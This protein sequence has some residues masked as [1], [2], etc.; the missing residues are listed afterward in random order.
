[1][2]K[3]YFIKKSMADYEEGFT[4]IELLVVISIISL[5]SSVVLGTLNSARDKARSAKVAVDFH[6]IAS[7]IELARDNANAVIRVITGS[8][9]S[10]CSFAG[11]VL[12]NS[13]PVAL[14]TNRAMWQNLGFANTPLDPWGSPYAFDENEWE[15][16]NAD[17]DSYD[18]VRSPGRNGIFFDSDDITYLIPFFICP[19]I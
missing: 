8:P 11:G 2:P 5:L 15:D 6:Q 9:C 16:D 3:H 10:M 18:Q 19:A 1:V 17:C 14:A 7:Q 4:L 12:A 13:Q